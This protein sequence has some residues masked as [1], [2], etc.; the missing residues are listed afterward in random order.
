MIYPKGQPTVRG[1]ASVISTTVTIKFL[2]KHQID[3]VL[4]Y[5]V[6]KDCAFSFESA[7]IGDSQT[8]EEYYLKIYDVPW[9]VSMTEIFKKLELCD[10]HLGCAEEE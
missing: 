7:G 1:K 5:L 3:S 4:P 6:E 8:P 2:E 9:A 10:Y